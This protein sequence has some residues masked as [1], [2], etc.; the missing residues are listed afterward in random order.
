MKKKKITI[1][2]V[3]I[4]LILAVAVTVGTTYAWFVNYVYMGPTQ[5]KILQIDSTVN[6]YK[7]LDEYGT[8][9]AAPDSLSLHGA[10][11]DQ[12]KNEEGGWSS[13]TKTT[14]DENNDS[15]KAE[16][17]AF[18][19][20]GSAIMLSQESSA[21]RFETVTLDDMAPSR[22]FTFKFEIINYATKT[23]N[24]TCIFGE[25]EDVTCL[26]YLQ[27]R[28][29]KVTDDGELVSAVDSSKSA[30]ETAWTAFNTESAITAA[31]GISLAGAGQ[32]ADFNTKVNLWLQI[33]M[34]P[35][36]PTTVDGDTT[37]TGETI[38]LPVLA[39]TLAID[40]TTT[41]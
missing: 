17:Y 34:D 40:E 5:Y 3:L 16:T 10:S 7:G 9:N 35:T 19:M 36:A 6:M 32:T 15:Y 12:Y 24:L 2:S 21:T 29:F 22:V 13:Y 30:N 11:D 41:T 39:I 26:Q 25:T 4:T 33:R 18:E 8:Y 31:S 27:V 14:F 38:A 23:A 37:L 28:M 1:I 20:L